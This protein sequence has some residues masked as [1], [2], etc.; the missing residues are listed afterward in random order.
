MAPTA[1]SCRECLARQAD[2]QCEVCAVGGL[3]RRGTENLD[4]PHDDGNAYEVELAF[5]WG[6]D[7]NRHRDTA[8]YFLYAESPDLA[9]SY[10][11]E[12]VT[13]DYYWA[14]RRGKPLTATVTHQSDG[15]ARSFAAVY[16][17]RSY[18]WKEG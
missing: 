17:G 2:P 12:A 1:R 4:F 7:A 6:P 16:E 8:S 3:S 14:K 9:A 15:V 18:C 10:A 5:E 11:G 13:G